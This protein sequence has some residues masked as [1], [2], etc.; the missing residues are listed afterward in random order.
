MITN[1]ATLNEVIKKEQA[2]LEVLDRLIEERIAIYKGKPKTN[3]TMNEINHSIALIRKE[4][5][6]QR[7]R[8]HNI[9]NYANK[10]FKHNLATL[11]PGMYVSFRD[12]NIR[13]IGVIQKVC[14]KS[15]IVRSETEQ[16]QV[17]AALVK[18]I[19][20]VKNFPIA[21]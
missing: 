5:D 7:M 18:P 8:R 6:R 2:A 12:N 11:L 3:F 9:V 10:K 13:R 15:F 20:R 21:A 17:S 4:R 16:W 19:R 1:A 14:A